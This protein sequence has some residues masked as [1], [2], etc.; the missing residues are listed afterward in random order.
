MT[1]QERNQVLKMIEAGK[2]SPEEGLKLL[3]ALE[4]SPAEDEQVPRI[5]QS[6]RD[7]Q[8]AQQDQEWAE[9]DQQQAQQDQLQAR[10]DQ[11]EAKQDQLQ[12][13]QQL[14][15][16]GRF[17][18]AG[19]VME[20]SNMEFDPRIASIKATVQR[21]WQIPLWI[22]IGITILSAVGMFLIL[23]GPGLNF[24]FYF[25]ILPILLG[26]L[27]I[28]VA[29]GAHKARWLFV[30]IRE[31]EGED[32]R[33]HHFFFGFPLPLRFAAWCMR[34]VQRFVPNLH[35]GVAGVDFDEV[36]DLFETGV[37]DEPLVVNVDEGE[38][39]DRVKVY[40]G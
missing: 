10:Q 9:V 33:S 18:Q 38:G 30:D 12:G 39:G 37:R 15:Q 11:L 17:S 34:M 13:Q 22:G 25:M 40:I 1:D 36:I 4:Q 20:K 5:D 24:W 8:Q 28:V 21:L 2:V 7:Q 3:Q 26:V 6:V 14:E 27:I 16:V 31:K 29:V 19:Q 35:A 23:R 32:G